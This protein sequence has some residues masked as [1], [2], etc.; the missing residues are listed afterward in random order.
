MYRFN[1]LDKINSEKR[2][3]KNKERFLAFIFI[4]VV[5]ASL[6][7]IFFTY[8]KS[9]SGIVDFE[10]SQEELVSIENVYSKFKKN[11]KFSKDKISLIEEIFN[12]SIVWPEVLSEIESLMLENTIISDLNY[13]SN[14]LEISFIHKSGK[15][16]KKSQIITEIAN[17]KDLLYKSDILS[18]YYKDKAEYILK[19]PNLDNSETDEKNDYWKFSFSI[20]LIDIMKPKA[21][22]TERKRRFR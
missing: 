21:K 17:F 18:K 9:T 6:T 16:I 8:F 10:K 22:K 15:E 12:K 5:F 3:K 13:N 4:A 7:I 19:G 1:F 11:I 20:S 14:N 2:V